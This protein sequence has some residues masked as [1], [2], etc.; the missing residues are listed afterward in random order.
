MV[1]NEEFAKIFSRNLRSIMYNRKIT[2]A[3]MSSEL[4]I[5]KTTISSWLIS[6]S[7]IFLKIIIFYA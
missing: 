3:Q 2:Q 1:S 5:A 6:D 7:T 4:K